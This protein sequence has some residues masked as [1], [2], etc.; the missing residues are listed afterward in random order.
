M[1]SARTILPKVGYSGR[2]VR[3]DDQARDVLLT[4]AMIVAWVV[5][6]VF[7]IAVWR[8]GRWLGGL[9]G[10][11]IRFGAFCA[12]AFHVVSMGI[13]RDWIDRGLSRLGR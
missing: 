2:L 13:I 5:G 11:I 6:F 10:G 1:Q 3:A 9:E 8:Y 4:M 12:G 7:W